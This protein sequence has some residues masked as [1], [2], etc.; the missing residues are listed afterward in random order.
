VEFAAGL[1]AKDKDF[2]ISF[3]RW[4]MSSHIAVLPIETVLK[5]LQTVRY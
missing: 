4:D 2:L 1:V 3:G 5:S